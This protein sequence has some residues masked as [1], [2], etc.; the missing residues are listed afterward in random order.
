MSVI[1]L[2][3]WITSDGAEHAARSRR[4]PAADGPGRRAGKPVHRRQ[5]AQEVVD[6]N[7]AT[8]SICRAARDR[9]AARR[10]PVDGVSGFR[11]RNQERRSAWAIASGTGDPRA[12]VVADVFHMIRGGGSVDDLLTL[13]GDSTRLLPH[14]RPAARARSAH[15]E[16][17]GPRHGRRRDRRPAARDRQSAHDRLP[18][19]A[20]ARAIQPRACGTRTRSRSS[21]GDSSGFEVWSKLDDVRRFNTWRACRRPARDRLAARSRRLRRASS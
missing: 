11:R 15:P 4:L 9:H 12:T 1:A 18:R 17:R 6:L 5:P 13:T 21:S 2:H 16:G 20:F 3:G 19:S 7:R 8:R 10:A 14:Q